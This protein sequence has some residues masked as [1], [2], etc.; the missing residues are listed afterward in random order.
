MLSI[1]VLEHCVRTD[2]DNGKNRAPRTLAVL[3]PIKVVFTNVN[4]DHVEEIETPI[5]PRDKE[6]SEKR[7]I[8]LGKV[9]YI[10]R[11]DF[12]EIDDPDFFGL[13]PN[14]EVGLKYAGVVLCK[15]VSKD[16]DGNIKELICTYSNETKK[17]QGRIHWIS[18]KDAVKAEVRLY[19][20][21]FNSEDPASLEDSLTDI[22]KNSLSI[23]TN[24][25]VNK[26]IINDMKAEKKHFQFERLG[27]FFVDYDTD[28]NINRYVFNLTVDSGDEKVKKI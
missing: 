14:K 17:T 7:K 8:T 12:R 26:S 18:E 10:E 25:L 27:Y 15:E 11:S 5:F 23:K 19:D 1:K 3:D 24:A 6:A 21:L 4:D 16:S 22:N 2:L 13:A 9:I 20:Y 28:M